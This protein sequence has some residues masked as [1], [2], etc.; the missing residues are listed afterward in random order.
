MHNSDTDTEG[1]SSPHLSDPSDPNSPPNPSSAYLSSQLRTLYHLQQFLSHQLQQARQDAGEDVNN[2]E[3]DPDDLL[4]LPPQD[5]RHPQSRSAEAIIDVEDDSITTGTRVDLQ[6]FGRWL[7]QSIP[8][9][10]MLAVVWIY[11]HRN[12]I[13][14][15]LCNTLV[16]MQ[17]NQ[18]LKKQVSLKDKRRAN[19]LVAVIIGL[20]AY[21]ALMYAYLRS[22]EPW[23]YLMLLPPKQP[24]TVWNALW[25]VMINDFFVR[26]FTMIFKAFV[27]ILVGHKPP[28]KRKAQLYSIVEMTSNTYRTL[29]PIPIWFHYFYLVE[30]DDSGSGHVFSLLMSGLYLALKVTNILEKTKQYLAFVRAYIAREVPYGRYATPDQITDDMCSICQEKMV[31]P[32]ILSCTHIFCEDCVSEWFERERTCPLCRASV[33]AAGNRSHSD[34]TTSILAQIF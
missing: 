2:T 11:Q 27:I 15:F 29:L 30:A 31:S 12:G 3:N 23:R 22:E 17:A 10:V 7:E 13:L 24:L 28:H 8:F 5:D 1:S 6:M 32:I 34:G 19:V 9:I 25:L 33:L 26:F 21:V 4:N 14:V 18:A 20:S 16:F